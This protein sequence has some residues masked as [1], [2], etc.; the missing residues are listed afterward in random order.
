[1]QGFNKVSLACAST[2]LCYV[3]D[4]GPFCAVQYYPPSYDPKEH[5]SLNS[6]HGKHALGDRARKL[7]KGILIVRFELPYNIWCDGCNN[8]IGQGVR[9]NAEKSKVG[10][11]YTTPIWNFRCKC[12]LCQSWFE[13]RTDPQASETGLRKRAMRI[14]VSSFSAFRTRDMSYILAH[15]KN[16]RSGIQQRTAASS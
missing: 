9:Y 5:T 8:H 3:V 7:D 1:M 4:S 11:Y 15:D 13:I 12:H 14:G 2:D 16:T 6:L 10:M